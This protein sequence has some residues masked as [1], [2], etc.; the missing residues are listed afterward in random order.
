MGLNYGDP[1][2]R[3]QI[4]KLRAPIIGYS[5]SEQDIKFENLDHQ[6]VADLVNDQ[7]DIAERRIRE[8]L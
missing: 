4:L 1:R 8:R 6:Q 7:Y 3:L 5:L 2:P